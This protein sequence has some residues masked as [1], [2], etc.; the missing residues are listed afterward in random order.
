MGALC[1]RSARMQT[2][3][4]AAERRNRGAGGYSAIQT[5]RLCNEISIATTRHGDGGSLQW[6]SAT[7]LCVCVCVFV[8]IRQSVIC[9]KHN[10]TSRLHERPDMGRKTTTTHTHTQT[11]PHKKNGIP[12]NQNRKARSGTDGL[13]II[14]Q[15][16]TIY[17]VSEQTSVAGYFDFRDLL[18]PAP[19]NPSTHVS[20]ANFADPS[21]CSVALIVRSYCNAGTFARTGITVLVGIHT[22]Y[23]LTQFGNG[24]QQHF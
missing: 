18:P 9:A 21:R 5:N 6:P 10:P 14:H 13:C 12:L 22:L 1:V 20:A 16:L 11:H 2:S 23:I 4:K 24:T 19:T 17:H 3:G 15:C 7:C 8:C